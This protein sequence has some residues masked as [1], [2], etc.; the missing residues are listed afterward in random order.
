[1]NRA[2]QAQSDSALIPE[3]KSDNSLKPQRAP[4]NGAADNYFP[5]RMKRYRG[6]A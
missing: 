4:K 2:R 5:G 3:L 1:M 6:E